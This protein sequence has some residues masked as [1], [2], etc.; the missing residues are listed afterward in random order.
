MLSDSEVPLFLEFFPLC[1]FK[2]FK[3]VVRLQ[4]VVPLRHCRGGSIVNPLASG[5][6]S[7]LLPKI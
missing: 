1:Q 2:I 6:Q 4:G 3:S 7:I 5:S